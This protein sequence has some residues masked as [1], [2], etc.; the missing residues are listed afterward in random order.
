MATQT[1]LIMAD[2]ER[3]VVNFLEVDEDSDMF[4]HSKFF[5]ILHE[6]TFG[7]IA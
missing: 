2:R 4:G 5:F 1:D 7:Q 3:P 6:Q